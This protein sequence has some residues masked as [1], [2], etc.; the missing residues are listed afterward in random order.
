MVHPDKCK[1]PRAKDAFEVIG[2]AHKDLLDEESRKGLDYVLG[3]ARGARVAWLS[4]AWWSAQAG[5][6]RAEAS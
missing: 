1:H 3:V 6:G 5:Q 2:A 4:R